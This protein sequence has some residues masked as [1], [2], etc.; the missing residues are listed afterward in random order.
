MAFTAKKAIV[1]LLN[2]WKK[3]TITAI[4]KK[5]DRNICNNYRPVSLTSMIVKNINA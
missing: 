5:G 2:M 3:A 4:H 1:P